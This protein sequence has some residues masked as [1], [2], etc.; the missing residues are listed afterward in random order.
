MGRTIVSFRHIEALRRTVTCPPLHF[1]NS[2]LS[3][4]CLKAALKSPV[5]SFWFLE[6]FFPAGR[7]HMWKAQELQKNGRTNTDD[8]RFRIVIANAR[9]ISLAKM[10][11]ISWA[12]TL[13]ASIKMAPLHL[14]KE[15]F[16]K[17]FFRQKFKNQISSKCFKLSLNIKL[18]IV[19]MYR[20]YI[21]LV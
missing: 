5:Q 3:A 12:K 16:P 13:L 21:F 18:N 1:Q 6:L 20:Q 7:Q 10:K 4:S 14:K 9:T 11:I 2:V 15:I 8:G 19:F 17:N